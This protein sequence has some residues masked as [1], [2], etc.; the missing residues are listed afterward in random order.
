MKCKKM[1]MSHILMLVGVVALAVVLRKQNKR[2]GEQV[3]G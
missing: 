2:M 1:T 3:S